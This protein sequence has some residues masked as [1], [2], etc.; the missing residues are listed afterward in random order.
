M[1]PG[2]GIAPLSASRAS[3]STAWYARQASAKAPRPE[4]YRSTWRSRINGSKMGPT[5]RPGR[6]SNKGPPWRRPARSSRVK[7]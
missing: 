3:R 6:D 7:S 1:G 5:G 4:R 2:Q